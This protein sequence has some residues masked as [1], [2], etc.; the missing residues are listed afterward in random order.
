MLEE[1][2]AITPIAVL[3][4]VKAT[5]GRAFVKMSAK[6]LVVGIKNMAIF[7]SENTWRI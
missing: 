6:L 3:K 4:A 7:P 2:T 1:G 5:E